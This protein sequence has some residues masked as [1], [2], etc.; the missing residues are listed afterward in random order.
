LDHPGWGALTFRR[1]T[2]AAGDPISGFADGL[3]VF[4]VPELPGTLRAVHYDHFPIDGEGHTYHD[5]T[6]GN[7]GAPY[8]SDAV[9]LRCGPDG[10]HVVSDLA[11]GEWLSYTVFVPEDGAYPVA[12]T[13][14]TTATGAA[15]RVA[16]AGSD[17]TSDVVL[18]STSGGTT[19]FTL[20]TPTLAAGVQT[21]RL[22]VS[23]SPGD[24]TLTEIIVRPP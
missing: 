5:T 7:V 3:P 6:P 12:V 9:D 14:S 17:L 18:P 13:Y 19:T 16:T 2:W 8:R 4:A 21:L 24:M 1:P 15:V 22:Y 20:G 10:R 23:G 11:D